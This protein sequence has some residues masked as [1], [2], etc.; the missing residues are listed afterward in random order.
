MPLPKEL[1]T[2]GAINATLWKME[3]NARIFLAITA[4]SKTSAWTTKGSAW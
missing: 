1:T 2:Y 3:K 4:P